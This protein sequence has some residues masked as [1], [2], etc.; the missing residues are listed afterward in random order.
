[1]ISLILVI[2]VINFLNTYLN[3]L[4]LIRALNKG[5]IWGYSFETN[6]ICEDLCL[7]VQLVDKNYPNTLYGFIQ[8]VYINFVEFFKIFFHKIFWMIAR[9]RPYYSDL[10]NFYIIFYNIIIYSSFIYGF[11]KKPKHLFSLHCINFYILFS[12]ILVGLTFADWSGRFSLYILPFLM[13]FSSYGIL[14][15]IE[16]ILNMIKQK[17]NYRS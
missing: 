8:F 5:I 7:S 16:K 6:K 13:I 9:I 11:V 14:V 12:I 1:M 10:H 4:N 17:W 3:E 2:P 15:F